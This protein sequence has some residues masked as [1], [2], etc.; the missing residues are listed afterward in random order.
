[1]V[2]LPAE[3][4][5]PINSIYSCRAANIIANISSCPGSQSSQTLCLIYIYVY[6]KLQKIKYFIF[7]IILL[8]CTYFCT[9]LD[10]VQIRQHSWRYII[11]VAVHPLFYIPFSF[12][13]LFTF[14]I[15][16]Q[17]LRKVSALK[18]QFS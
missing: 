10:F 2:E 3:V 12:C 14:H 1:M 4:E 17:L 7:I 5:I 8:F 15:I 6:L 13:L 18:C 16:S 9:G 11:F